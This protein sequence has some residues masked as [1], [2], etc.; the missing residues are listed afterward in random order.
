M[1]KDIVIE[2]SSSPFCVPTPDSSPTNFETKKIK[3]NEEYI[4]SNLLPQKSL[5]PNYVLTLSN[6]H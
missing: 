5:T 4:F 2:L 3:D 6:L 1:R